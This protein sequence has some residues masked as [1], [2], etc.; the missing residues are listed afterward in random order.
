MSISCKSCARGVALSKLYR[1][2]LTSVEMGGR[3]GWLGGF[4]E[5]PLLAF[6]IFAENLFMPVEIGLTLLKVPVDDG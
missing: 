5:L 4:I 2:G 3:V 6:E 1:T